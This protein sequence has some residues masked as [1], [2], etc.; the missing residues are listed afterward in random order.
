[1]EGR[2]KQSA[3]SVAAT[4]LRKDRT[5]IRE[6]QCIRR[7]GAVLARL[8]LRGAYAATKQYDFFCAV[9]VHH[10]SRT[11]FMD[12]TAPP[13]STLA[14]NSMPMNA[15]PMNPDISSFTPTSLGSEDQI[16]IGA[17]RCIAGS[18]LPIALQ[19]LICRGTGAGRLVAP[20]RERGYGGGWTERLNIT[21]ATPTEASL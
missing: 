9:R 6:L 13:A 11:I 17:S 2:S 4:S 3:T 14:H 15:T 8:S 10:L 20:R 12:F 18:V 1:M 5:K 21:T 16:T 7:L 19:G